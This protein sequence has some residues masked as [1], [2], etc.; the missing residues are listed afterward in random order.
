M[1]R[2]LYLGLRAF[3]SLQHA[4]RD[5][6]TAAGWLALTAAGVTGGLGLDIHRSLAYQAFGFLAA[7][8]VVAF[9]AAPFF[10]P[11][12]AARRELPPYAT[13]GVPLEYRVSVENLGR[14]PLRGA[15]LVETLRDPRPAYPEW[16]DAREPG[17]ARRNPVDRALGYFRWRWLIERRTPAP[18]EH[19]ALPDLAPGERASVKLSLTARRR[20]RLELAGL[21]AARTDFLGLARG[22]RRVPSEGRVIALPRRYRVPELALPGARR[23]QL[24][25]VALAASAGDSEEFIGLRDYRPGDP[26]RRLHWKSMARTGRPIVKEYQNEFFER[27]ALVLDTSTAA[28]EDAAFEAAVSVAASF[29]Y[30]IDTRECLLDLLFVGG[31]VRT[32]TAGR[33]QL[34]LENM[35]EVLAGVAPSAPGEFERLARAVLGQGRRLSSC[36]V[37]LLAWDDARRAF[38]GALR[39]SGLDVRALLISATAEAGNGLFVV[40]PGNVEAGLAKL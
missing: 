30:A 25:G 18:L 12:I 6:L 14:R 38:V 39:A 20:G 17:E 11:R 36:I 24:G 28:G 27:H 23:Y 22:L 40:N 4:L 10:R 9:A 33:G 7:L 2:L 15:T 37:V 34:R 16:K 8:L 21:T 3:S 1:R 13:A 31:E 5:R 26:L 35:L 32:Y 19:V 29:V